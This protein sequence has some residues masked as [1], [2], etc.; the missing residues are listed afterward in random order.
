MSVSKK[1]DI[2]FRLQGKFVLYITILLTLFTGTFTITNTI[3]QE[4]T[5]KQRL[6][7]ELKGLIHLVG[8]SAIDPL[9][10]LDIRKLRM[11]LS[12]LISHS[13]VAYAYIFDSEGR[14]I[15][16]GTEENRF[17]DRILDDPVSKKAVVTD[18]LLIQY[19]ENMIDV[20]QPLYL[21]G[22]KLGE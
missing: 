13:D 22:K 8:R 15:T 11:L 17:H 10:Q 5:F 19:G 9:V 21:S 7:S 2:K 18:T 16:D 20:T 6:N 3:I 4:R 14:I 1:T 12:D